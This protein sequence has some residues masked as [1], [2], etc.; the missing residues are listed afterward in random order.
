[1]AEGFL[2]HLG[3]TVEVK[4]EARVQE[5]EKGGAGAGV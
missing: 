1:M 5:E 2:R 3:D 4:W